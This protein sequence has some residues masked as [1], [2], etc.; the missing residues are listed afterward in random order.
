MAVRQQKGGGVSNR[1]ALAVMVVLVLSV[2]AILAAVARIAGLQEQLREVQ[3]HHETHRVAAAS[4]KE[5][6][7]ELQKTRGNQNPAQPQSEAAA[8]PKC[9]GAKTLGPVPGGVRVPDAPTSAK[10]GVTG[11]RW[12]SQCQDAGSLAGTSYP[13]HVHSAVEPS[14]EFDIVE[15]VMETTPG[16]CDVFSGD[17]CCGLSAGTNEIT[18]VDAAIL[19][20]IKGFLHACTEQ[21]PDGCDA[22]DIGAN[23]GTMSK[24]MLSTGARV[25]AIEPQTD[26]AALVWATACRNGWGEK[27]TMYNNA[28]TADP[29]EAGSVLELG[30]Q[31]E[32]AAN[33]GFRPD[34]SHH[35]KG[36]QKFQATKIYVGDVI[37]G[38][39]R[40]SLIKI[41]TDAIDHLLLLRFIELVCRRIALRCAVPRHL[42]GTLLVPH[43]GDGC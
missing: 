10:P 32:G 30:N 29:A 43:A 6:L 5:Q 15:T 24:Y 20:T 4:C 9:N 17:F 42:I 14:F 38:T 35:K 1:T 31:A 8:R 21:T 33:W 12:Y 25:R 41:D 3:T 2:V 40:F 22:L 7:A 23:M 16:T 39:P 19:A 13:T 36:A 26:L 18:T 37:V 34:G 28:V 27:M 11:S